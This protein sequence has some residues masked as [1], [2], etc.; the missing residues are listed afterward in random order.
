ML[1]RF[2]AVRASKA[3]AQYFEALRTT[4][5][6]EALFASELQLERARTQL[7]Y[8]PPIKVRGKAPDASLV[9]ARLNNALATPQRGIDL[10]SPY[11]V[12]GKK[13]TKVLAQFAAQGI[14]LR[15]LT[16]SLA[17]TDVVVVHAGY[18]K[19]RKPLLR[20]GVRIYELKAT[21]N[22]SA[23]HVRWRHGVGSSSASLHAKTFSVDRQ[24]VFVGSLNLDPR[25][26]RLNTEMGLLI[27]SK[28]LADAVAIEFDEAVKLDAYEVILAGDGRMEW[29][30]QTPTG[31]V[32]H[33]KEPDTTFLRRL[34][35]GLLA[36]LPIEWLL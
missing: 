21:F 36:W 16:N 24:R 17:A 14:A 26:I 5:L 3:A 2:S 23:I 22:H 30:E 33:R 35:V 27:D 34:L 15:I 13:G 6:V 1:A 31:V 11:F 29:I 28:A 19:R 7:L 9:F 4:P 12:P 18:A 8:D 20:N 32:R 10:V 25:S